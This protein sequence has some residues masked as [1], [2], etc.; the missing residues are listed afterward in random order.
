MAP[1]QHALD[2]QQRNRGNTRS[3]GVLIAPGLNKKVIA[4]IDPDDNAKNDNAL[5]FDVEIWGSDNNQDWF[6]VIAATGMPP[7]ALDRTTG[8]KRNNQLTLKSEKTYNR[9]RVEFFQSK[10]ATCGCT[11][12]TE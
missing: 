2:R 1:P 5:T 12:R 6:K 8:Q 11:I 9:Y 7:V 3:P 10:R 4:E